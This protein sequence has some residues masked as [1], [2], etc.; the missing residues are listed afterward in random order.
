MKSTDQN[1]RS[2]PYNK[3]YSILFYSF[4]V[5]IWIY[6]I[7]TEPDS[8]RVAHDCSIWRGWQY[9]AAA[10]GYKGLQRPDSSAAGG[11]M[12]TDYRLLYRDPEV[13]Q[14]DLYMA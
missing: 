7:Q 14:E 8:D 3:E 11:R 13:C 9:G 5:I 6:P 10:T 4:Y 12:A 1:Y 2:I